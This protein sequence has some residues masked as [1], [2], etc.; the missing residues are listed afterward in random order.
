MNGTL[1]NSPFATRFSGREGETRL[2]V[3]NIVRGQHRRPAFI[4]LAL[5]L[6]V[7]LSC[8]WFFSFGAKARGLTVVM[9]T[10]YYDDLGNYIEI[11][12]AAP[13][14]GGEAPGAAALD[15]ALNSLREEYAPV[16]SGSLSGGAARENRCLFYLT[17]T[18][19]YYNFL[20]YRDEFRTD[21]SCG[22]V[23]ALVYDRRRDALV[24]LTDAL[25]LAGQTE[26]G[27]CQALA[28]QYDPQLKQENPAADLCIQSQQV[29][30]F[31][32]GADGKV[33]FY[34]TARIDDRDD[35]VQDAVS[36][37]DYLY[38]WSSGTFAQ[39]DEEQP[40]VPEEECAA[41]DPPLYWQW[42]Q[43]GRPQVGFTPVDWSDQARQLLRMTAEGFDLLYNYEITV[44]LRITQG[45]HTLLMARMQGAPHTA[46]LDDLAIGVWD[47]DSG[48]FVGDTYFL[49][50]DDARFTTWTEDGAD[51][52]LCANTAIWQGY[53][54]GSA[55][56]FLRFEN[57][58]LQP[59]CDL[60]AAVQTCSA[61]DWTT[62]EARAMLQPLDPDNAADRFWQDRKAIPVGDGFDLYERD[63]DWDVL[64][65]AE[66]AQWLYVGHVP[67][68]DGPG[69]QLLEQPFGQSVVLSHDTSEMVLSWL[70]QHNSSGGS[71]YLPD[72]I[73]LNPAAGDRHIGNVVYEGSVLHLNQDSSRLNNSGDWQS[74]TAL[75]L[76]L[77]VSR[78]ETDGSWQPV[79]SVYLLLSRDMTQVLGTAD[80]ADYLTEEERALIRDY[81]AAS[82][83]R[84]CLPG[85][86][87]S[88]P[89]G[90]S[91]LCIT[92][93]QYA[94]STPLY[95]TEG[96]VFWV[97]KQ[98]APDGQP[99]GEHPCYIVLQRDAAGGYYG[100]LGEC[101][102][103]ALHPGRAALTPEQATL[104]VC[105]KLDDLEVSLWRDGYPGGVGPGASLDFS[106]L[107]TGHMELTQR[108]DLEPIYQPGDY[109]YQ[110]DGQLPTGS[111]TAL[112]Y[113]S[114]GDNTGTIRSL[115]SDMTALATYRGVR[116]GDSREQVQDLYP[117]AH[118]GDFWG[119]YPDEDYLWYSAWGGDLAY[120]PA[121]LFFFDGQGKVES[122]ELINMVD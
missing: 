89:S 65:Q 27:L 55:L 38:I 8:G 114:A 61:V 59:I 98:T 32:M 80:S 18:D 118:S 73:P 120:G 21:L 50:G 90:L 4:I 97:V 78:L 56:R 22:H 25:T 76:R 115:R 2:R 43:E 95:E 26:E 122:F 13:A 104:Q 66:H 11:P 41:F 112:C 33:L 94:G 91:Q 99:D 57:G 100:V 119:L 110:A 14:G 52:L 62:E 48:S 82:Y 1:P 85:E 103:Y 23:T 45:P 7:I 24:T 71:W 102:A 96:V 107:D 88:W 12:A 105:Y 93:I 15:Q 113:H 9:E 86:D 117:E 6:L 17:Q 81:Y 77:D 51:Y 63:P 84:V 47:S 79:P 10:Q 39:Y 121:I 109:W 34:L 36:G 46:G 67:L 92:T 42:R 35:S 30:G 58:R 44:P 116:V 74:T 75:R 108:P 101:P 54:D 111:F 106:C 83:D 29:E 5:A 87:S 37:G 68:T 40:L 64:R 16:L 20:F 49:P 72:S 60:P 53:E 28:D 3:T 69:Q 31:R 19:R 70:R